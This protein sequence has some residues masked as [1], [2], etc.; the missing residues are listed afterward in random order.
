MAEVVRNN[1]DVIDLSQE[2]DPVQESNPNP[3]KRKLTQETNKNTRPKVEKQQTNKITQPKVEE[4]LWEPDH[5]LQNHELDFKQLLRYIKAKDL[6]LY[7]R[8]QK[9]VGFGKYRRRKVCE[10]PSNYCQWILS[11]DRVTGKMKRIRDLLNRCTKIFS[12]NLEIMMYRYTTLVA[13][14]PELKVTHQANALTK[15]AGEENSAINKLLKEYLQMRWGPGFHI[16]EYGEEQSHKCNEITGPTSWENDMGLGEHGISNIIFC[17]ASTSNGFV[18]SD[19]LST[20]S[21][22]FKSFINAFQ[23]FHAYN[24]CQ[25]RFGYTAS[26]T[27]DNNHIFLERIV[28]KKNGT[29]LFVDGCFG[30]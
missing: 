19:M 17:M 20:K 13:A 11:L 27:N 12:N 8:L 25:L 23:E 30:S 4:D 22:S 7:Q 5:D 28:T 15:V 21:L 26:P 29:T 16:P 2:D 6:E 10:L 18:Q 24:R 1:L 3:K 14:H 9:L